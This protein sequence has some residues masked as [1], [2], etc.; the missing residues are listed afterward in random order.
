MRGQREKGPQKQ[1]IGRVAKT[2]RGRSGQIK[3]IGP[4]MVSEEITEAG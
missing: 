1:A 4:R 3:Q 2:I